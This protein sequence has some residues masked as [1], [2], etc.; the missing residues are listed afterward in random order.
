MYT[1]FRNPEFLLLLLLLPAALA[2][3]WRPGVTGALRFSSL[4]GVKFIRGAG[5][6]LVG[7]RVLPVLRGL[8]FVLLVVGLARPQR[9]VEESEI[10]TE[11]VDII[12]TIDVS[13]S[14]KAED[15]SIEGKRINRL[16]AVKEVVKEFIKGRQT[17][18][19]GM[20]VFATY[21]YIQCPLTL[22]YG[23][24]LELLDNVHL[25]MIDANSTAVGSAIAASV[26]RLRSSAAKGKIVILLTDGRNNT[27]RIDPLTAAQAAV[28]F[29]VRIYTIGAGSDRPA[30]MPVDTPFGVQY[31]AQG[32]EIDEDT[33]KKIAEIT[34]GKY[35]RA[36][37]TDTLRQVYDEINKLE[38]TPFEVKKHVVYEERYHGLLL[39]GLLLLLIEFLLGSR[40]WRILQAA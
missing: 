32:V 24:L 19:I 1:A 5:G 6:R 15:F 16:D 3:Y 27:G 39:V 21:A 33:L 28:P 4:A 23:I 36:T 25:G 13:G 40:R 14:M 34:G 35:F 37:D 8:A 30:P 2:Y 17:D 38:K 20:V 10:T 9:G 22:D 29:G 7:R 12:L 31:V 26:N 11:G 18:R